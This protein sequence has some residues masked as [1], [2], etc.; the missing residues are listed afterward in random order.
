MGAAMLDNYPAWRSAPARRRMT[1]GLVHRLLGELGIPAER[2]PAE[3]LYAWPAMR[4]ARLVYRL[5]R[6][7]ARRARAGGLW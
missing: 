1:V 2:L 4:L 3:E 5:G 6:K 7:A